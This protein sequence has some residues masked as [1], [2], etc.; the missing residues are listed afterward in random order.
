[1]V[2]CICLCVYA[3]ILLLYPLA[4]EWTRYAKLLTASSS[5]VEEIIE[6]EKREL[7]QQSAKLDKSEASQCVPG[8]C[9]GVVTLFVCQEAERCFIESALESLRV[10]E[11]ELRKGGK[12]HLVQAPGG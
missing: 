9:L 11:E 10:R 5:Q 3:V 12:K 4:G 1:M 8:H 6:T 2:L 7:L